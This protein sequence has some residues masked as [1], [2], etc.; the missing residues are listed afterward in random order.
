MKSE[1]TIL[2]LFAATQFTHIMDFMIIMPLGEMLMKELV[3]GSQQFSLLV[4]SYTITAGISGLVGAFF[5]DNFDRKKYFLFAYCGFVIGTFLCG[6]AYSYETLMAARILTGIFG[7]VLSSTVLA[8]VSDVIAPERRAWAIGIVMTAFS[9]ASALGLPIGLTAA[10][11]FGWQWPFIALGVASL[12]LAV[13]VYFI[14]PPVNGHLQQVGEVDKGRT[15]RFIRNI[16]KNENQWMALLFTMLLIFGQ[17]TV[18]PFITPYLVENVGFERQQITLVYLVGGLVTIVSNPRIGRWADRTD[19]YRVFSIM[20]LFSIVPMLLLTNLPPVPVWGALLVT[21]VFF[22]GIGGRMVP[23]TAI[24]TT[25]IR[26]EN[27]G[28]F[29]SLNT[30]VQNLTAGISS[31]IAGVL[32]TIPEGGGL[33]QGFWRVGALAAAFTLVA[34]W[35]IGRVRK[36]NHLGEGKKQRMEN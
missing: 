29:M 9:L 12:F 20:A 8:I 5:I 13:A 19:R 10:F 7:G 21:G 16:P 14:L 3:I 31:V 15:L 28:S 2:Y 27:R 25:V 1:R 4:A 26:P 36:Y 23:S 22:L 33:V 11:A 32:V 30:S 24:V 34:I 18:I 35:M 17:F 6:F